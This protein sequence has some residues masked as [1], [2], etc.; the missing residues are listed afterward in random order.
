MLTVIKG[1]AETIEIKRSAVAVTVA[2]C[3]VYDPRDGSVVC[4]ASV[5]NDTDNDTLATAA[6][7]NAGTITTTGSDT[8]TKGVMY[9]VTDTNTRSLTINVVAV[10]GQTVT[11]RDKLPFGISSGATIVGI[12]GSATLTVPSTYTGDSVT[13]E[14]TMSN[15]DV[16]P[17][18]L[19]TS[20]YRFFNPVDSTDLYT[21][22]SRLKNNEPSYQRSQGQEYSPQID[23]AVDMIRDKF[24][25]DG[26]VLD[27]IRS[28]KLASELIILQAGLILVNMGYDLAASTD[29]SDTRSDLE[30]QLKRAYSEVMGATNIWKD[31][32]EDR[33]KDA[34]ELDPIG[35]RLVW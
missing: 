22:W 35:V 10:D 7:K 1:K 16:Y 19:I 4:T 11:L 26:Y 2:S 27:R 3:G 18:E 13:I 33:I 9:L 14:W 17:D 25:R 28:P 30:S 15:S 23:R 29:P 31:D 21:R 6:A 24:W 34:G 32:D 20:K 8:L 12:T 5:A